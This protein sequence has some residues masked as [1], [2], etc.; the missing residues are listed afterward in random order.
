MNNK[1][2]RILYLLN[3][4]DTTILQA[5]FLLE[6]YEKQSSKNTTQTKTK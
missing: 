5:I 3:E 4:A 1:I 6:Q 2:I